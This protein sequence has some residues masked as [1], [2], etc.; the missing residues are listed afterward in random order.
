MGS[1]FGSGP[2]TLTDGNPLQPEQN[3]WQ[4]GKKFQLHSLEWNVWYVYW[5]FHWNLS[6]IKDQVGKSLLGSGAWRWAWG[7]VGGWRVGRWVF[8]RKLRLTCIEI[9]I[10]KLRFLIFMIDNSVP[11]KTVLILKRYPGLTSVTYLPWLTRDFHQLLTEK[12]FYEFI[13]APKAIVNII[14]IAYSCSTF[15]GKK[16]SSQVLCKFVTGLSNWLEL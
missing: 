8:D 14:D 2:D 10:I 7:V 16:I 1:C 5:Q 4:S 3:C 11:R 9:P 6:P 15:I 12:I 13:V